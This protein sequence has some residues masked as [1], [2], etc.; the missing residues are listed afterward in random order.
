MW[1]VTERQLE[2]LAWVQEGKSASDIAG[3]LGL[4]DRTVEGHLLKLCGHLGVKTR[5]Q[6]V[7]KARDLGLLS[8][9]GTVSLPGLPR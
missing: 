1:L 5:I 9:D 6:A 8:A 2:C 4:S 7:L 3:I